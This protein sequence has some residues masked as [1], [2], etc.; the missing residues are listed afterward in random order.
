MGCQ[1]RRDKRDALQLANRSIE[2]SAALTKAGIPFSEHINTWLA[3]EKTDLP[4]LKAALASIEPL[5]EK[6]RAELEKMP[7]P[8][9]AFAVTAYRTSALEYLKGQEKLVANLKTIVEKVALANPGDEATRKQVSEEFRAMA[10]AQQKTLN[11]SKLKTER[12]NSYL[13]E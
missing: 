4:A 3:G 7:Y 6:Y 5:P 1:A 11:D 13:L 8:K 12:L 9:D 2:M 10:E